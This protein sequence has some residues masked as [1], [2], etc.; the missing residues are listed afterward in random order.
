VIGHEFGHIKLRHTLLGVVF[1]GLHVELP[2]PLN[3]I[4]AVRRFLSLWWQRTQEMSADRVGVVACGRPSKAV[5]ALVKLSVGPK[6]F[7]DVD[8]QQLARQEA[9]LR[10][11]WN[12]LWGFLGQAGQTHPFIVRRIRE[13]LKFAAA[14]ETGHRSAPTREGTQPTMA[15]G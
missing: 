5:T 4:E 2:F 1:G 14:A 11:G 12:R 6:L 7:A 13:I 10:A 3:M 8:V 9:E 15:N